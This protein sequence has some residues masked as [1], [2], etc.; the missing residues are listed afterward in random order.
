M[1]VWFRAGHAVDE[2]SFVSGL[3]FVGRPY[4]VLSPYTSV[5][6]FHGECGTFSFWGCAQAPC[7]THPYQLAC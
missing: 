7:R 5:R 6:L 3:V 1:L 4:I 2:Q